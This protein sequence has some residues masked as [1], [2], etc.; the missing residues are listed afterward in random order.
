MWIMNMIFQ[1]N[2]LEPYFDY[3]SSVY[4]CPHAFNGVALE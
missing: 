1:E 4:I 3:Y 2:E